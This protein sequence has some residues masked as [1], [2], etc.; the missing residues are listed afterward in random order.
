MIIQKL[1]WEPAVLHS[2]D[3]L[4]PIMSVRTKIF[5]KGVT[6]SYS[7]IYLFLLWLKRVYPAVHRKYFISAVR[8]LF[9]SHCLYKFHCRVKGLEEL[10]FLLILIL[11]F[12]GLIF[13]FSI[14]FKSPSIC[15]RNCDFGMYVFLFLIWMLRP[16]HVKVFTYSNIML[17]ITILLLNF[18]YYINTVVYHLKRKPTTI[19][20][21]CTKIKPE[22]GLLLCNSPNLSRDTRFKVTL[23]PRPLLTPV[24]QTLRTC[25]HGVFNNRV[26]S[27]RNIT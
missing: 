20:Y 4:E 27:L 12:F 7:K 11:C 14:L 1:F 22:A 13:Y 2:M 17:S 16:R 6:W 23:L 19:T 21:Y 8:S 3:V 10:M 9:L 18:S 5:S 24:A 25:V 26:S 15:K